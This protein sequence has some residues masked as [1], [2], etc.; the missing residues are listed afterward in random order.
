MNKRGYLDPGTGGYLVTSIWPTIATIFAVIFSAIGAFFIKYFFNPIKKFFKNKKRVITLLI[1]LLLIANLVV[2]TTLLIKNK[3]L[4]SES[5]KNLNVQYNSYNN[6]YSLV[7]TAAGD[8]VPGKKIENILKASTTKKNQTVKKT[9]NPLSCNS[10]LNQKPNALTSILQKNTSLKKTASINECGS[11][12]PEKSGMYIY[13]KN[14]TYPGYI[15]V[16]NKLLDQTGKVVHAWD[17]NTHMGIIQPDGT[18]IAQK[19]SSLNRTSSLVKYSFNGTLIWEKPDVKPHHKIALTNENTILTIT[20]ETHEYEDK[21]VDFDVIVEFD[22]DGNQIWNWSTWNNLDYIQTFHKPLEI[23]NDSI[24]PGIKSIWGGYY[25]YYHMNSVEEIPD[26]TYSWYE[27]EQDGKIIQPFKEGNI[28]FNFRHGS[29]IFILDKDTGKIVWHVTQYDVP[30][31]IQGQHD[32]TMLPS[33]NILIYDNGRYRKSTRVIE[34]N[35]ITKKIEWQYSAPNFFTVVMGDANKLANGN[36]LL[37]ETVNGRAFEITSNGTILW[38]YFNPNTEKVGSTTKRSDIF[39][40]KKYD[41]D[42]INN[43]LN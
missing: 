21:L 18:Y 28:I 23:T 3:N 19:G 12:Q 20:K 35:P 29:M 42:F 24:R 22:Q 1:I 43:L 8:F 41:L 15:L 33:G 40:I 14:Q 26:N 4:I 16:E 27:E 10:N 39:Q 25:D 30:G 38:E 17:N 31:E 11:K 6:D 9:S 13:D 36:Y 7:A 5:N 32:S 37:S 34:L 2:M